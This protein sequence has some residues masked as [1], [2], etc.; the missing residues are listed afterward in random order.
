MDSY[1][2][3]WIWYNL[4]ELLPPAYYNIIDMRAAAQAVND[5]FVLGRTPGDVCIGAIQTIINI[6]NNNYITTADARRLRQ[7]AILYQIDP[8]QSI[9][10]LRAAILDAM[11]TDHRYTMVW[12]HR[13]LDTYCGV[14]QW[15]VEPACDIEMTITAAGM[16]DVVPYTIQRY[17]PAHV[18][19]NYTTQQTNNVYIGT[20]IRGSATLTPAICSAP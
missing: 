3:P 7:W 1:I 14:G 5:Y 9:T 15:S 2:T 10:T 6:Y 20:Y 17:K 19:I 12:L 18:L 8:N 16:P 4:P 11:R 13:L